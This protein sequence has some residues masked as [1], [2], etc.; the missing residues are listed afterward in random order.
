[1]RHA[2][3]LYWLDLKSR[4]G[5]MSYSMR[6][7]LT[8]SMAFSVAT[9]LAGSVSYILLSQELKNRL[10]GDARIM[11]ENLAAT[12]G[13]GDVTELTS[14]VT[15]QSASVRDFSSLYLFVDNGGKPVAGNFTLT[16]PFTGARRVTAGWDISLKSASQDKTGE[17]YQ[18]FGLRVPL[19]WI[20]TARD[21]KWITDSRE[22]LVQSVAWGLGVA[23]AISIATAL[24]LARRNEARINRLNQVLRGAA[25]GDLT[26]RFADDSPHGD[27]IARV[28]EGINEMLG[29][30]SQSMES[31]RQVSTDIAH[32][33]RSP[34]TRL[35]TRLEPHYARQD[36]PPD[37][38]EDLKCAMTEMDNIAA[39]FDAV[40]RLAQI[41]SGSSAVKMAPVNL[42]ETCESM[43]D[44][45]LP[46]AED[47]GHD[48]RF[49][50]AEQAVSITGEGDL[51][52][53]AVVNLAENAF[54][55]CPA[56]ASITI[57][58]GRDDGRPFIRVCDSGPGIPLEEHE[59]VLG[60]FYRLE[61]SRNLAGTGLGLS[62]VSAIVRLHGGEIK[63]SEN[64][65][66]LR[67]E[68][69]F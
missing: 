59:K 54:R 40:L 32:D 5:S 7:A 44:M 8:V 43:Y 50:P 57:E 15:A 53:Q 38:R 51:L 35:R 45:L 69:W 14:Q 55:H 22:V 30:L 17:V 42:T 2:I 62:L 18:A 29:R 60:R 12:L 3:Y 34:L 37:T 56:P 20:I 11:A 23:L 66:G 26:L 58:V 36:L 49:L 21:I 10:A 9:I 25:R 16:V 1:M 48:F 65:P 52:A 41:E 6:F 27:D 63:L 33:L 13:T 67:A 64:S 4:F 46:V 61:K 39:T 31:L 68:L 24:F 19:G 28:A 47:M